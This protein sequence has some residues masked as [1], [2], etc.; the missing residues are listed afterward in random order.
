MIYAEKKNTVM[1]GLTFVSTKKYF[2]E[3]TQQNADFYY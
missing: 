3:Y 1:K 2:F